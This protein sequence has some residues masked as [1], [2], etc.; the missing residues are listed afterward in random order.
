MR[1]TAHPGLGVELWRGVTPARLPV[2]VVPRR[3]AQRCSAAVAVAYGSV[4]NEFVTPDGRTVRV[5][6]GIAHFLEHKLFETPDGPVS[7][8]FAA[9]GAMDNAATWHTGTAY[10]FTTAGS[11]EPCL[12]LLLEFVQTPRFSQAGVERE[13]D[14]IIQEIKMGED[15]PRQRGYYDLLGAM[16]HR[17]PVRL[18]IAGTAA[19]VAA[20]TVD[21]L[22]LCYE[23]F[24]R[25]GN[26]LLLASG[27]I[28]PEAVYQQVA[29]RVRPAPG[30]P[31]RLLPDEPAG[32]AQTHHARGMSVA[33]PLFHLGFK[34]AAPASGPGDLLSRET[35]DAILGE[36]VFGRL[37]PLYE[38]LYESGLVD[39]SFGA[40]SIVE[41]GFGWT[42]VSGRS[43]TPQGVAERIRARLSELS[44]DGIDPGLL[45]DVRNKLRGEV[46]LSLDDLAGLTWE[47]LDRALRGIDFFDYPTALAAAN[48]AQVN[49]RLRTH[50]AGSSPALAVINPR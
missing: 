47:I 12:D 46:V 44:A 34:D 19:S 24:Y 18:E 39:A 23:T 20:I 17:H 21:Q 6:D 41:R 27:D 43:D 45:E 37:S 38:E 14:I 13:R 8:R 28:D 40:T 48:Q 1:A 7:D 2:I 42:A 10:Y 31:R 36:A 30:T 4:D 9:L 16:Y 11:F 35:L 33:Q 32:N 26:M 15:D 49:Q 25:P 29:A 5:P 3:G 22:K 50:L